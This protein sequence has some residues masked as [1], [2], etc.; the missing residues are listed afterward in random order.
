MSQ[1]MQETEPTQ[2]ELMKRAYRDALQCQSACNLSGVLYQFTRHMKTICREPLG[3][4]E[5]NTHPIVKMF[6]SKLLSLAQMNNSGDV[7]DADEKCCEG[8]GMT[9]DKYRATF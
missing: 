7:E 3:T 2:E 4:D 6:L 9:M 8:A 5:R 1:V